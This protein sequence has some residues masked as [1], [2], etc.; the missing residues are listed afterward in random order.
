[1]SAINNVVNAG[2]HIIKSPEPKL[3][4]RSLI[5]KKVHTDT[6]GQTKQIQPTETITDVPVPNIT[7][8]IQS[9][10]EDLNKDLQASMSTFKQAQQA[11]GIQAPAQEAKLN[12][13]GIR[14]AG[15]AINEELFARNLDLQQRAIDAVVASAGINDE[16]EEQY[17]KNALTEKFNKIKLDMTKASLAFE[18]ELAK[19]VADAEKRAASR[20]MFGQM[21]GMA[22]GGAVGGA[23]GPMGAMAGAQAGG[24]IGSSFF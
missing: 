8:P 20:K 22:V 1:M 23:G 16:M 13:K 21:A 7:K 4:D 2:K 14:I 12:F 9:L 11:S 5:A 18:K 19:S 10:Q 24:N 6:F 17:F 15:H 3:F